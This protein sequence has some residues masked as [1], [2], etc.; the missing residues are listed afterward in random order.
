VL[1]GG[2]SP[3]EG[4]ADVA[5]ILER[6]EKDPVGLSLQEAAQADIEALLVALTARR[7]AG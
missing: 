2:I 4:K 3:G 6:K 7:M 1:S 5:A